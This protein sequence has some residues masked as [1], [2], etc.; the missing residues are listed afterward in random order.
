MKPVTPYLEEC[1]GWFSTTYVLRSPSGDELA[2]YDSREH[3]HD[4]LRELL[5]KRDSG[6]LLSWLL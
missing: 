6:G 2:R 1:E 4:A 5:R 3:A